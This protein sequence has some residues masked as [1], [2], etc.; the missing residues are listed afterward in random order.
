MYVCMYVYVCGFVLLLLVVFFSVQYV[1]SYL[2]KVAQLALLQLPQFCFVNFHFFN[3]H[4]IYGYTVL[5]NL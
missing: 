1:G 3:V 4:S 5:L 2:I